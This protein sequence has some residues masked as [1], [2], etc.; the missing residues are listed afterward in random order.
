MAQADKNAPDRPPSAYV[1]FSNKV[2]EEVKPE[3]L[4]FTAIAKRVGERWQE[5]S[6]AQ[7]D[8]YESEASAAKET[9]YTAMAEYKNTRE[10]R[11]YDQY[12]TDFKTTHTSNT[13]M[14]NQVLSNEQNA[15]DVQE[16][17]GQKWRRP[18][19]LPVAAVSM[20]VNPTRSKPLLG[21]RKGCLEGLAL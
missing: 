19:A 10:Y 18:K 17:S 12:L 7:K 14:L 11:D 3:N 8:P 4:S 9:Y 16:K 21:A 2:R 1:I 20:A 6:A 5:L 15:E 13:G